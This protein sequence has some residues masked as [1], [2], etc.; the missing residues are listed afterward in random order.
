LTEKLER[1]KKRL[2]KEKINRTKV[3][4]LSLLGCVLVSILSL[5]K[6]DEVSIYQF[7]VPAIPTNENFKL[8]K[9]F[10]CC[11]EI[12]KKY[13]QYLKL[14]GADLVHGDILVSGKCGETKDIMGIEMIYDSETSDDVN[15]DNDASQGEFLQMV[16]KKKSEHGFLPP[17]FTVPCP[18]PLVATFF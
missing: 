16:S 3:H 5:R 11:K 6:N 9:I 14:V 1:K 13:A 7:L 12:G 10:G 2:K 8:V 15:S 18:F 4:K 17:Q